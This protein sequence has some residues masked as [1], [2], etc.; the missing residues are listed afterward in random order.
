MIRPETTEPNI[1]AMTGMTASAPPSRP[2]LC[3]FEMSV[4]QMENPASYPNEPKKLMTASAST[5]NVATS[6]IGDF[7]KNSP[8]PKTMVNTPQK[9]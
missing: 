6:V 1:V 5:T 4:V 2:R 9:I 3:S 7:G 8:T